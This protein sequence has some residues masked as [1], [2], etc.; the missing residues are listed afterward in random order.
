MGPRGRKGP[1]RGCMGVSLLSITSVSSSC[2]EAELGRWC[3]PALLPWRA[4]AGLE[5]W[6]GKRQDS[7]KGLIKQKE[8]YCGRPGNY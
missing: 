2:W 5:G 8:C 1:G 4:G 7:R 3:S 6:G